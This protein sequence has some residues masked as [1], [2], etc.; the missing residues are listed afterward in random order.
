MSI[1]IDSA[2]K[3]LLTGAGRVRVCTCC[4]NTATLYRRIFDCCASCR[5]VW[6]PS[7]Y[8]DSLGG[9]W[10]GTLLIAGKC[11]SGPEATTYT[12]EEIE[13]TWPDTDIFDSGFDDSELGCAAAR[14]AE[15]CPPC[16]ECCLTGYVSRQCFVGFQNPERPSVCCNWGRQ[17]TLA[18]TQTRIL[19]V[20]TLAGYG[21]N[22]VCDCFIVAPLPIQTDECVTS[23]ACRVRRN[24]EGSACETNCTATLLYAF[25]TGNDCAPGCDTWAECAG[26]AGTLPGSISAIIPGEVSCGDAGSF[27]G[28]NVFE[29]TRVPCPFICPVGEG[30]G[31]D[32]DQKIIDTAYNCVRDCFG[33]T[34]EIRSEEREFHCQ[35]CR[36][37]QCDVC[38]GVGRC[39]CTQEL[40]CQL[41]KSTT[42]IDISEW[43]V[44]VDDTTGCE[45]DP[46]ADYNGG[47]D[48]PPAFVQP[49]DACGEE[50]GCSGGG[51]A[52]PAMSA[53]SAWSMF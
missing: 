2:G 46:C 38:G 5:F 36:E 8:L 23:Q 28:C 13:A 9:E 10:N 12:R 37:S 25:C 26:C 50:G 33:G 51:E 19:Q 30:L 11:Y 29:Q 31:Q 43:T 45:V 24:G 14:A 3:V 27:G 53:D 42:S 48:C 18:W 41:F 7:A 17:W 49:D 15:F 40:Q 52:R 16:E 47:S 22:G 4:D 32:C 34:R 20:Q 1:K 44:T 39:P 35:F 21:G 6:V